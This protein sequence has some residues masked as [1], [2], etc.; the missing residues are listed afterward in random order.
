MYLYRCTCPELDSWEMSWIARVYWVRAWLWSFGLHFTVPLLATGP[1]VISQEATK[2]H[3]SHDHFDSYYRVLPIVPFVF[4]ASDRR[5]F[6][7]SPHLRPLELEPLP[8]I[9]SLKTQ[10]DVSWLGVKGFPNQHLQRSRAGLLRRLGRKQRGWGEVW[11][12][13][14]AWA[15]AAH[16]A[17]RR[18]GLCQ[19]RC[20]SKWWSSWLRWRET[21][22]IEREGNKDREWQMPYC[23]G[24]GNPRLGRLFLLLS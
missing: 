11:W 3:F 18:F 2:D 10:V 23:V 14:L 24:I 13:V 5:P 7:W 17:F 19:G 16:R 15:V 21:E 1:R 9:G 8:Q 22:H 6:Q 4:M 12:P 20:L